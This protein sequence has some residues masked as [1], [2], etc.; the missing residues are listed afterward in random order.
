MTAVPMP[1]SGVDTRVLTRARVPGVRTGVLP[2][3]GALW[4]AGG[5]TPSREAGA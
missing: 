2:Y 1:G 4:Y 5:S 3:S